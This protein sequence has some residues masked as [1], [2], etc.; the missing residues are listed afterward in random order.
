VC[1]SPKFSFCKTLNSGETEIS[2]A[3]PAF[4]SPHTRHRQ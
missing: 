1:G 2:T 4:I 3:R